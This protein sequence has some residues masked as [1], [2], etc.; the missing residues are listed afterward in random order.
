MGLKSFNLPVCDVCNEAWLPAAGPA[1]DNIRAFAEAQAVKGKKVRCGKC[2]SPYW[3]KNY[4]NAA[5]EVAAGS[6]IVPPIEQK[7]VV[8]TVCGLSE[9]PSPLLLKSLGAVV[10]AATGK[11]CRHRLMNCEICSR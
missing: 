2:K 3:D 5:H 6:E 9:N 1:R 8:A 7:D 4:K 11:L 10:K